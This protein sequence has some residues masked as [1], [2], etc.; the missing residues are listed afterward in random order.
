MSNTKQSGDFL[1][2]SEQ[3]GDWNIVSRKRRD[4]LR[5]S[6]QNGECNP[7]KS[8]KVAHEYEREYERDKSAG[9]ILYAEGKK[10]I[11][12]V[13]G[14][15]TK[16][17]SFPKGHCDGNET[18]EDC[19]VRELIEETGLKISCE[20]LTAPLRI[21]EKSR[22]TYFKVVTP[23][24]TQVHPNDKHE[25][26]ECTW[27]LTSRLPTLTREQVNSDLWR[28]ICNLSIR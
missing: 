10:F 24:C 19:A 3:S 9:V 7:A 15:D 4:F 23:R 22:T 1:C 28:F 13:K 25:I 11:L 27:F 2:S 16:K 17:W 18:C 12:L 20:C 21:S 26:K 6:D 5:S 14:R 8:P